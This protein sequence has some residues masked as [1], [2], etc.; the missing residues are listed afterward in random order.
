[1]VE[2]TPSQCEVKVDG[3]WLIVSLA[4]ASTRFA[5]AEKRCPACHGRVATPGTFTAKERRRLDHRRNHSGC[6][7]LPKIY[8][9]TPSPHPSPVE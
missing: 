6:P 7:L 9:G 8:C 2:P 5:A 3:R 4:E 1:M